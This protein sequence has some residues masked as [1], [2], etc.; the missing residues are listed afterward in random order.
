MPDLKPGVPELKSCFDHYLD[1]FQVVQVLSCTFT[2]VP[3]ASW[4][5]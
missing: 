2:S 4:D 1:L 5:S 3:P